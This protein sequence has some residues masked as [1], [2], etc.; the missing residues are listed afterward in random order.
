V[1]AEEF[2]SARH[3]HREPFSEG[4]EIRLAAVEPISFGWRDGHPRPS[5]L[6]RAGLRR[7]D[8]RFMADP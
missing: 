4:T 1:L 2:Q 7:K 6:F 8:D 5:R 3:Q